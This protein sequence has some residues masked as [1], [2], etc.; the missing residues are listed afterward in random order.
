[1]VRN[2]ILVGL[3][4][5]T[6]SI[7]RYLVALLIRHPSFPISTFIVNF[8][9]SFIIGA[10]LGIALKNQSFDQN[11]RIFLATG[12]CGGFTTF[13]TFSVECLQM[14]QQQRYGAFAG[15]IAL[16]ISAGI[17]AVFAGFWLTTHFK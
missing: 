8:A 3:G 5:M 4:G 15:Y 14:L 6:G 10:V 9:G 7:L 12:V 11:W 16:S 1:M 13:S 17:T 2:L